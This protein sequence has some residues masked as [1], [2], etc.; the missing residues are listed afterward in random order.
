ML[1]SIL[2][3]T[4]NNG[5]TI[6]GTISSAL[7][8]D[9]NGEYEVIVVN[10]ASTDNT[11]EVLRSFKDKK[12]K[13]YSNNK[14]VHMFENHNLCL[15]YAK[16]DYVLFCHSD[17]RLLPSALSIITKRLVE[18]NFPQRYMLNGRS[19]FADFS[20]TTHCW[21]INIPY[22]TPISGMWA[23]YVFLNCAFSPSGTCY[24]RES[25]LKMGGF[26]I[27]EGTTAS[28]WVFE[29]D[30]AFHYW[31]YE[32]MD[33][34]FFIRTQASTVSRWS[35]EEEQLIWSRGARYFYSKCTPEEKCEI[36]NF[37]LTYSI[38]HWNCIF[39]TK[40]RR[41]AMQMSKYKKNPFRI[42]KL[43]KWLFIKWNIV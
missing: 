10:N 38:P 35:K 36:E 31:E 19:M 32:M 26:P 5:A 39:L 13:I 37:W 17:D 11:L 3:P 34:I 15:Q 24:H 23:K 7:E 21:G 43:I 4:Y 8:Q 20:Y 40:E 42:R 2:V 16:G 6:Y 18:R 28:D 33:R 12:L 25:I 1:F 30:A 14:T 9:Y 27:I 22:N 29:V 41:L